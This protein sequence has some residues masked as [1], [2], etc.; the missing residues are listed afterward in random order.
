MLK[1]SLHNQTVK[2]AFSTVSV[3]LVISLLLFFRNPMAFTYP[4]PWS[5]DFT[6]FIR[7]EYN[8][9]FPSTAFLLYAGYIHLL[10][11]IIAW[12]S[13]TFGIE[14]AMR[15]MNLA[16]LLLKVL[17]FYYIYKSKEISSKLIKF[18]LL[19]YLVLVPFAVE[20]YN[21]VTNL[22]WWLIPLMATILI[23]HEHNL[24][25]FICDICILTLC[26]LT[27]VNSVM[28]ALPCVY[29]MLKVKSKECLGKCSVV[30]ICACIQLYCL[31]TSGRSSDS[32]LMY[33]GGGIDIINLFVNRVIY[34]T[35]FNFSSEKYINCIILFFYISIFVFNIYYY[36]KQIF[37][38]FIFLFSLVYSAAILYNF[39]KWNPSFNKYLLYGFW[40]ERYFV[41]LR[42]CS[43]V[44]MISSLNIF[45]KSLTSHHNYK[46]IMAYS[47]FLLCL[48]I[49]KNYSVSSSFHYQFYD[50]QKYPISI[51]S[52]FQ[53]YDDI[54]QFQSAKTGEIVRFHYDASP[55]W[56]C[57][58]P[59]PAGASCYLEKK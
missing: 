53:Y 57:D 59:F 12:F 55:F 44:L 29:L 17:T 1:T 28:F 48:I 20:I 14:D 10:P 33:T 2:Q 35:L 3:M 50:T 54:K 4:V 41:Y 24:T 13:M 46:R 34:H 26:G 22:Q 16:V 5:E 47:C 51:V 39:L 9:G 45:L 25:L 40:S 21:N 30:I 18:S 6:I 42:I 38:K 37:I 15:I 19:A 52:N 8:I 27:G 31:Y 23:K 36:R 7:D 56:R 58:L 11:R 49:L 43:F 32:K